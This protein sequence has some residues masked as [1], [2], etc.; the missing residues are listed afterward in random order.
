M[1][2]N[3]TLDGLNL[4]LEELNRELD[5]IED[6]KGSLGYPNAYD[7]DLEE[8]IRMYNMKNDDYKARGR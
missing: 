6:L 3:R 4:E 7:P 2:L 5:R 1:G 8:D